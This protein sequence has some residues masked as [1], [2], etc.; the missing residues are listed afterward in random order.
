MLVCFDTMKASLKF[1]AEEVYY[2]P[3]PME[4]HVWAEV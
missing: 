2:I 3:A 4:H 1:S